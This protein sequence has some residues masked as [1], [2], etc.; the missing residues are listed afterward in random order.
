MIQ[1]FPRGTLAVLSK[2][3]L[4]LKYYWSCSQVGQSAV[5]SSQGKDGHSSLARPRT[6]K[7]WDDC[8]MDGSDRDSS[9]SFR[10]KQRAHDT[11]RQMLLDGGPTPVTFHLDAKLSSSRQPKNASDVCYAKIHHFNLS[12]ISRKSRNH[13]ASPKHR[14]GPILFAILRL[15]FV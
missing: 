2:F 4:K 13:S 11:C 9:N 7:F 15:Y 14:F 12:L 6:T 8:P 1:R 10:L 5:L 3:C